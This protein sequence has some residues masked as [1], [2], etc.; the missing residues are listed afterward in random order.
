MAKRDLVLHFTKI[1][2]EKGTT[3]YAI[4]TNDINST[5]IISIPRGH[6]LPVD[7]KH[8]EEIMQKI[9]IGITR[10]A[11]AYPLP[12]KERVIHKL[13]FNHEDSFRGIISHPNEHKYDF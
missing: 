13:V 8:R 12:L 9:K 7:Q 3:H 1:K 2:D 6:H 5:P 10:G 4:G 11:E